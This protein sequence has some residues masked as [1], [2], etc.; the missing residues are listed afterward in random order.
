MRMA[1]RKQGATNV[2][3]RGGLIDIIEEEIVSSG[4]LGYTSNAEV[5][6]DAGRLLILLV[7]FLKLARGESIENDQ[8]AMLIAAL[9]KVGGELA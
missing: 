7:A 1:R 3:V 8:V 2:T 5:I 6:H 4:Y 9:R